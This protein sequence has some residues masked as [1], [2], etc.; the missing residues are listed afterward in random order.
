MM[1]R[2]A[3][4][5]AVVLSL[6][7][8]GEL[9][10]PWDARAQDA[11]LADLRRKA[12]ALLK[13]EQFAT[14]L[15]LLERI[16]AADP[17]SPEANLNLGMAL[18][19]LADMHPQ[20]ERTAM[21][22]RARTLFL[23][24]RELGLDSSVVDALVQS[25]PADGSDRDVLSPNPEADALMVKGM[26]AFAARQMDEAFA[27]YQRA[28]GLDPKLYE[29]ALYIG[30]VFL[31]RKDYAGAE[32]WYQKAIAIDPTRET[33]YRYSAT[34][35][36]WQGRLDEARDRYVE[37]FISEPYNRSSVAG[38][39]RWAQET[40]STLQ[41]PE[42]VVPATVTVDTNGDLHVHLDQA[43]LSDDDGSKAWTGY[44]GT[45]ALWYKE[46]FARVF[47]M[48]LVY[49]RSLQEETEALRTVVSAATATTA[50]GR[51]S[52]SLSALKK[53][54]DENLL[55]PYVLFAR[56]NEEI[57]RDY[58][59]YLMQHRDRLRQYVLTYLVRPGAAR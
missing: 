38:L 59:E 9:G 46:R 17:N 3:F 57:A 21:R 18:A 29:A 37:A 55:E 58:P 44:G 53:L 31:Y 43:A 24:A 49:R 28:L 7:S 14:A 35:L 11:G 54:D 8:L 6:L 39:Q 36:M 50:A 12:T 19:T 13:E 26:E 51:L 10:R 56:A 1:L 48:E 23:K 25:I 41:H 32:T 20:P 33:A 27:S 42:I 2:R 52:P 30:D 5:V 16:A 4:I 22:L 34:P 40:R 45:R 15:P 47:P